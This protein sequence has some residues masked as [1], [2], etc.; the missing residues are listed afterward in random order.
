MVNKYKLLAIIE[1]LIS[2]DFDFNIHPPLLTGAT[3]RTEVRNGVHLKAG[4]DFF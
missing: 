2:I 4:F 1:H 3:I